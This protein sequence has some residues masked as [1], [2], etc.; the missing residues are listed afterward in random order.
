MQAELIL[1]NA[2]EMVNWQSIK[3]PKHSNKK[4]LNSYGNQVMNNKMDFGKFQCKQ[5]ET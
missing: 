2:K 5:M 1:L 4:M 3:Q